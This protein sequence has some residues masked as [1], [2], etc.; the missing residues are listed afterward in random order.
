MELIT[1]ADIINYTG[2]VLVSGDDNTVITS[3]AIDSR[4][5]LSNGLFIAIKGNNSDGHDFINQAFEKG[6]SAVLTDRDIKF[7]GN[8]KTVIK[9]RNSVIA[10]QSMAASYV[11]K[12]DIPVVAITGSVGKT[13]TKDMCHSVLSAKYKTLKNNLNFNSDIGMPLTALNL[14]KTHQA[15]VFEM[16]MSGLGEISMMSKIAKPYIAIITNI[17]V[18]HIEKLGSR[19]NILKAKLEIEDGLV[20]DACMI[21]NGDD[22]LLAGLKGKLKHVVYLY[23]VENTK[24]DFYASNIKTGDNSTQMDIITPFGSFP[25]K[26][27]CI[28]RHNVS[29]AVA[30]CASSLLM[31]LS[32][33]ECIKGLLDFVPIRQNIF[34]RCGMT[35]IEDVYNASPDSMA[36]ALEVLDVT[37]GNKKIAVL[38]DMFELGEMSQ[39]CHEDVGKIA[40]NI[41]DS[42]LC[43]GD[44]SRYIISAASLKKENINTRFFENAYDCAEYL[45]ETAHE[46]DVIL[47]KGSRGMKTEECMEEFFKRKEN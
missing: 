14:D 30:A 4:K 45:T 46:K 29:N 23:S 16:G 36:A 31:G 3:I 15:A 43:F 5:V 13:T 1:I 28:G 47:F 42:I 2:A 24:C 11:N 38:S 34:T 37:E 41:C 33:E 26:I 19:E 40:A 22:A 9:V 39:V 17:G 10:L 25:V 27:N 8:G 21:L 20:P 12:F 35:I 7:Q 6:A 32:T 44:M 18:S